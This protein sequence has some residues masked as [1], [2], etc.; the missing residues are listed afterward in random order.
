MEEDFRFRRGRQKTSTP[1]EGLL[2]SVAE[3]NN[4][5]TLVGWKMFKRMY[6]RHNRL[7]VMIILLS[8]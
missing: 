2:I 5:V 3:N 7:V 6:K 4:K 1:E 8:P